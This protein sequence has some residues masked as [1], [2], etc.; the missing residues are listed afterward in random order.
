M[1]DITMPTQGA[2]YENTEYMFT[3]CKQQY[4]LVNIDEAVKL[5]RGHTDVALDFETTSLHPKDGDIRITSIAT[6][7][8]CVVIDHFISGEFSKLLP[9]LR[10]KR[11]W[12][13]NAKFETKWIDWYCDGSKYEDLLEI[14]DVDFLAKSYYGGYPSSLLTMVKRD[15]RCYMNKE[16]QN[17]D[18]SRPMLTEEQL[19]YAAFDSFLTW[20]LYRYWDNKLSDEQFYAAMFVFN[21]AVRGTI[22]C[23]ETGLELDIEYHEDTVALWELKRNTF[24]RYLR[25]HTSESDIKNLR[26]DKQIGDYLESVLPKEA[27]ANWPRTEKKKQMQFEGK[28][29]RAVSRH[30][31]YPFSRWLAALAGYKYYNKYL[32]T[33]G[34]NLCTSAM[35]TGKVH[36][37]FNIGQAATGRYS[38]SSHN[39][40]NIPRKVAVRK[41]F[42]T[43]NEGKKLMCLADYK[44]IEIRV[45]AE[46]TQDEQLL[47]DVIY[48]DVHAA[49]CAQIFDYDYEYV[50]EVLNSNGEGR[51]ANIYPIIK[52]QRSKAKGFT[53]QLLYGAGPTALS[54]VLRCTHDEAVEA[55]DK[56]AQRYGPAYSYRN[57]IY[58][59]MIM[60]GGFIPVHDGRTIK[61]YKDE[62][63]IPVAANYGIQGAAA[64]VMYRAVHQV[65]RLFYVN[66]L[67]AWLAAT[68]HDE[69]LSYAETPYAEAAMDAQIE[70]MRLAWLD[71]FP[72]SNTDNLVDYAIGNSWAAKP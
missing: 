48:G 55:I 10:G 72:N 56:W 71:I 30:F 12:V 9:Y 6:D 46:L 58:D 14:C 28:Y 35:F 34:E 40:Q 3:L 32:S 19:D 1:L 11:L 38:S 17:S 51:H 13:Y 5:L 18:W 33:Y 52:E 15:L 57:V 53:F 24:E 27:L 37:R 41:A 70:G 59:H 23:E 61:V 39:L 45:L 42:V 43:L 7:D 22:E 29:L 69:M 16:Q 67:P 8:F 26:S 65:H 2:S 49:S 62:Q 36:S 63:S 25:K 44:G 47:H 21:D 64:S 20:R 66:D 60:N 50:R 31:S 54:D 68:V 4:K